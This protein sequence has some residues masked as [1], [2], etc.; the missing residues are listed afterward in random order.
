M[1]GL[2]PPRGCPHGDLNAA[3]LPIPPHPQARTLYRVCRSELEPH[4]GPKSFDAVPTIEADRPRVAPVLNAHRV[5][6]RGI[7]IEDVLRPVAEVVR[8]VAVLAG[9][10][11]EGAAV[12]SK[13]AAQELPRCDVDTGLL[14]GLEPD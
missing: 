8:E 10:V 13:A 6:C 1:R 7:Q 3:R 12:R 2:E 4:V 5:A 11:D 14:P 9:P